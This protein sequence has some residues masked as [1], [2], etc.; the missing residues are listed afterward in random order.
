M[1]YYARIEGSC[2]RI[3][4]HKKA[5]EALNKAGH[6][7]AATLDGAFEL[8][9]Y[10]YFS[11]DNN[12]N[13]EDLMF[14]NKYRE[15]D[16]WRTLAPFITHHTRYSQETPFIQWRGE[17]NDVWRFIFRDGGMTIETAEITWPYE[18]EPITVKTEVTVEPFTLEGVVKD[19]LWHLLN[20]HIINVGN[21]HGHGHPSVV[22]AAMAL[23]AIDDA[24]T[25]ALSIETVEKP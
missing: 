6:T 19:Q 8:M 17:D 14:D 10:E 22:E 18:D 5:I 2:L 9:M 24:E 12:G 7:S 4:H 25:I 20:Q 21:E 11:I 15:E 16:I 23:K 13:V 3:T 1:G